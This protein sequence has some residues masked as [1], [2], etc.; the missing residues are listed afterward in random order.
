MAGV[1]LIKNLSKLNF[2][3][4]CSVRLSLELSIKKHIYIYI[5][6]ERERESMQYDKEDPRI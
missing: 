3:S 6:R 1:G 2:L 4:H 5:E